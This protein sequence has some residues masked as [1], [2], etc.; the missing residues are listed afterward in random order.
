MKFTLLFTFTSLPFTLLFPDVVV[1]LE[2]EQKYWRSTDL[3]EKK[4][5]IG[6][7]AYPYSPP[8]SLSVN[9]YI[10]EFLLK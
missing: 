1:V 6:G 2:L 5:R 9:S 8:S 10:R 3:A 4:A 7:F